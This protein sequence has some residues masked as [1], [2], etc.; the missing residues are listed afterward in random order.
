VTIENV[1]F[2]TRRQWRERHGVSRFVEAEPVADAAPAAEV[3]VAEPAPVNIEWDTPAAE[4]T[5]APVAEPVFPFP[6]WDST[7]SVDEPVVIPAVHEPVLADLPWEQPSAPAATE[8]DPSEVSPSFTLPWEGAPTVAEVP[9][10][11][12]E[13]P[14]FA[15]WDELDDVQTEPAAVVERDEVTGKAIEPDV[16]LSDPLPEVPAFFQR[17]RGVIEKMFDRSAPGDDSTAP[18]FLDSTEAQAADDSDGKGEWW[19]ADVTAAPTHELTEAPAETPE[20]SESAIVEAAAAE[21]EAAAGP[22]SKKDAKA[23]KKADALAAAEAKAQAAAD[24]KAAKANSKHQKKLDAVSEKKRQAISAKE[25]KEQ[26]LRAKRE[27]MEEEK[28]ERDDVKARSKREKK[29]HEEWKKKQK[30]RD[31]IKRNGGKEGFWQGTSKPKPLEIANA[32]RSLAIILETSPAEVDAVKMMAE[33]FAGNRIG[34]AFDRIYDRL[35]K[36]NQTLV[37]AFAPEEVFPPVVHNM[38]KVGA[39]TAKPGP[40]LRTAVDLMDSGNDNKRK[41]RNA[42]REPLIVAVLSLGILFATAWL[43]MPTFLDMYEALEMPVGVITGIVLV[44]SDISMWTIGIGAILAVFYTI[45]WFA[46]G[47]SSLRVRVAMDRYKLHAPLIGKSEQTGE[48]FQ[49]FNIL[50]SYLSVGATERESL[51][52]T[53]SAMENR[54]IKRHLRAIANGLTRG[55]KTFAQFLD[56]DM[57]PKLA[58]SI[59]AAGQRTGQ[60]VQVVKNLRDIYANESKVEGEQAV[61]KVVGFVSAISSLLFTVTATIVSVPPLEIFGATLGYNG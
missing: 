36:D 9:Q 43:V 56:D 39:K 12:G 54:A 18:V 47:R 38:L 52:N 15:V 48:A 11:E 3:S 61:E 8:Y 55:E 40:A 22:L 26:A 37:E 44:M 17:V 60:T 45:W 34:D 31:A 53:A 4:P 25:E 23:K 19:Q 41:M 28:V 46:F 1:E 21:A 30:R 14:T 16:A 57:F 6:D 5:P 51:L 13:E 10:R 29:A 58:R 50:N 35:V 49:M 7:D 59:L 42:V 27:A 20:Y 33:E 24:A 32:I 2:L